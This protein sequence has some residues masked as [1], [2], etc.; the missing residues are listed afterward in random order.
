MEFL[1]QRRL[2]E[3]VEEEQFLMP[4]RLTKFCWNFSDSN[5]LWFSEV[6]S[7]VVVIVEQ[8]HENLMR[9]RDVFSAELGQFLP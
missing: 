2:V 5:L 3:Q 8:L 7:I 1:R 9:L 6:S 4:K